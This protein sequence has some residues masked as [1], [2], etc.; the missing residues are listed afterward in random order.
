[1]FP[2]S[3]SPISSPNSK[4]TAPPNAASRPRARRTW[5]LLATVLCI[6]L[7][8]GA[9]L[10][11][12][13]PASAQA[14][15]LSAEI[16]HRFGQDI[17]FTLQGTLDSPVVEVIL[18]FGQEGEGLVRRVYP[19]FERG[20][21]LDVTHVEELDTG[22]FILGRE[23][24]AWWELRMAD[25][26]ILRTEPQRRTYIDE[27]HDWK[28]LQGERVDYYWYGNDARLA[29]RLLDTAEEVIELLADDV[30][31]VIERRV[32][33]HAY[34]D[35]AHMSRAIFSRSQAFDDRVLTLG[36]SVGNETL[37]LLA[38]YPNAEQIAAHE[39]SHVV[40]GM[41]TDNPYSALPRWLDEGLAMYAEGE[42]PDNN[43]R[44][45]ER[46]VREDALLSVRSMSS[47]S[48][49]AGEVDLYYGQ[50]YSVV[51]FM[52]D[53]YGRGKMREL[54][55]VFGEGTRQEEALQRVYGLTLEEL[56]NEWRAGL[57]LGPRRLPD[58]EPPLPST[59]RTG[60]S[61]DERAREEYA[62]LWRLG[63]GALVPLMAMGLWRARDQAGDDTDPS[64]RRGPTP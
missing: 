11:G 54:L 59:R 64:V 36:V 4:A 28:L 53:A 60:P 3:R 37:L 8:L 31:V 10:P 7:M 22:Q 42:L 15:A 16:A 19:S 45:L 49:R 13:A 52:L 26:A 30:G 40:V 12:L 57:G 2:R 1:M 62:G 5:T 29:Q 20:Q 18:F 23:L 46:G 61:A 55:L 33:I 32:H 6:S 24:V 58:A 51:T 50:A 43:R 17:T 63:A 39:L 27:N 56:D 9:L 47:Y 25:G 21:R 34:N 48:G 38:T 41:V 35:A 14:P 44:A